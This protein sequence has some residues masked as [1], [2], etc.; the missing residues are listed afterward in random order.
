MPD[1]DGKPLLLGQINGVFGVKGWVKV[2]D[3]SR[4]RGG[5]LDYPRWLLDQEGGWKEVAVLTGQ[6]H[7]KGVIA[8]L[9]NCT[10]RDE[11]MTLVGMKIAVWS[12][13]LPPASEG[14]FYW[15]QLRGLTV[16][17][18][19]GEVLGKVD[20][21]METGANDVLVV[22]SDRDRLIPY[23]PNTV[24][25]VDLEHCRILVDWDTQF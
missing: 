18:L 12:S 6:R 4:D 17:N 9:E 21:L 1:Q 11:A 3:Y 16:I 22:K 7:G 14:E 23:V 19:E 15:Y 10:G 24:H 8:H 5:I 13:W 20:H 2:F 25:E